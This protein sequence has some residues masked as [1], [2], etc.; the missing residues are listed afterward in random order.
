[1]VLFHLKQVKCAQFES[2][3][4]IMQIK[5]LYYDVMSKNDSK[6]S[7]N[8]LNNQLNYFDNRQKYFCPI[9][10]VVWKILNQCNSFES[11]FNDTKISLICD[12]NMSQTNPES[13]S[14]NL[15]AS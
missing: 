4:H 1:M 10:N 5:R 14:R 11:H 2:Q 7:P 3:A 12:S 15:L 13:W 8:C 6:R 9:F